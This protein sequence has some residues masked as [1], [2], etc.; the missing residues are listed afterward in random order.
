M[1]T[2]KQVRFDIYNELE[3]VTS[4]VVDSVNIT[5]TQPH[6]REDFPAI[7][8]S[9][10]VRE[11]PLN[12]GGAAPVRT[13]YTN[14]EADSLVYSTLHVASFTITVAATSKATESTLHTTLKDHF[15]L[16]TKQTAY[17][18]TIN[19]DITKIRLSDSTEVNV[20]ERAVK[21][22]AH[23]FT[24]DVEY[25]RES[26]TDVDPIRTITETTIGGN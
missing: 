24:L 5:D 21:V 2:Q 18:K 1:T 22:Y 15:D 26:T 10:E 25:E 11:N 3:Q 17:P 4:G 13:T 12:R 9:Y 23:Q 6:K 14:N 7:V 16:F 20:P 19:A 8:H